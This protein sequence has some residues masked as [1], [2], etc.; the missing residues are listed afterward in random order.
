MM[1]RDDVAKLIVAGCFLCPAFLGTSLGLLLCALGQIDV[2]LCAGMAG[3]VAGFA[4]ALI[5]RRWL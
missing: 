5:V 1:D 4:A 3:I 2:G